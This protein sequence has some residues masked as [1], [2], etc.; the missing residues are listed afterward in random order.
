M[1]LTNRRKTSYWWLQLVVALVCLILIS[2]CT[3]SNSLAADKTLTIAVE[4]T[5]PPFEFQTNKGE[6]QGFDV[7]LMNAIARESGFKITYQNLPFAGMIPALQARTIDAAVA[8]MTITE[9]RNKTVSFSR[10]YF[11][12]GLAI[13]IRSDDKSITGFES[14]NNKRIRISTTRN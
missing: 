5:Y 13:A 9:E 6:L 14:L 1:F 3:N 11:R 10:P 7:D 4:G 12:S 8:A 2:G